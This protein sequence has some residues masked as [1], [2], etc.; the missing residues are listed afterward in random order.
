MKANV[1]VTH[2]CLWLNQIQNCTVNLSPGGDQTEKPIS[3]SIEALSPELNAAGACN[4]SFS[5]EDALLVLVI[6]SDNMTGSVPGGD[7]NPNTDGSGWYDAVIAAKGGHEENAVAIG[8][9]SQGDTWCIPNGYDGWQAPNHI[10]FIEA[11]G[12]RGIIENV[13]T[14]DYGPTFQAAVDT[15]LDACDE[16]IPPD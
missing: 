15:V 2:V 13:C 6:V 7:A 11:F 9:I 14:Q 5:R 8:F 10:E 3:A 16:F 1:Y 12:E 4:D